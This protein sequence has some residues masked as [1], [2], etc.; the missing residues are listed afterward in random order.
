MMKTILSMSTLITLLISFAVYAQSPNQSQGFLEH[1][2]VF[3]K[4]RI[5]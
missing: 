3:N 4:Y 2:E 1:N 5:V